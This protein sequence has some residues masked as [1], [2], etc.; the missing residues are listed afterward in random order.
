MNFGLIGPNGAGK[1]TLL[2]TL[3]ERNVQ[4]TPFSFANAPIEGSSAPKKFFIRH[5]EKEVITRRIEDLNMKWGKLYDRQHFSN[6][7]KFVMDEIFLTKLLRKAPINEEVAKQF[8]RNFQESISNILNIELNYIDRYIFLKPNVELWGENI[9]KR[10]TLATNVVNNLLRYQ[11]QNE[12]L[13]IFI[14]EIARNNYILITDLERRNIELVT[15][16][17]ASQTSDAK[18]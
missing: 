8:I 14:S 12:C 15:K 2:R 6:D 4:I 17:I 10:P 11:L 3:L 9:L 18:L 5:K 13:D 1:S 7:E 16:F